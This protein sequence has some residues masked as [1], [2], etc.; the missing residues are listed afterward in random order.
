[1]AMLQQAAQA[2]PQQPQPEQGGDPQM[3]Q[4]MARA[5]N[6]PSGAERDPN[7]GQV[8]VTT[9]EGQ[10]NPNTIAQPTNLANAKYAEEQ[11]AKPGLGGEEE[12]ATP[13]EQAAY[14]QALEA[15]HKVLYEDEERSNG[16]VDM[17]QAEDKIGSVVKASLMIIKQ[18]DEKIDMDENIIAEITVD[19]ADRLMELAETA[20]NIS[21]SEQETKAVAGATWEGVMQLFGMDEESVKEMTAGMSPEQIQ[22]YEKEYAG[23]VAGGA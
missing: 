14:D 11:N 18:L 9:A 21:F 2:A 16:I 5:V 15:L 23:Y 20:H 13:E 17:I 10:A 19:T 6:G 3:A 7:V 22:G 8:D 4:Q 12:Q 1:M